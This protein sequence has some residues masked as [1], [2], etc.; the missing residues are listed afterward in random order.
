MDI[1][2]GCGGFVLLGVVEDLRQGT[3]EDD[4][5]LV[6]FSPRMNPNFINHGADGVHCL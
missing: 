3:D 6:A 5:G 2:V 4:V 1:T